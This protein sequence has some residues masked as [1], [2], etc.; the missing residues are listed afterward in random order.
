MVLLVFFFNPEAFSMVFI[1]LVWEVCFEC[2]NYN[3]NIGNQSRFYEGGY[4]RHI[5]TLY[6]RKWTQWGGCISSMVVVQL[7]YCFDLF[8]IALDEYAPFN[9]CSF[10]Q[11]CIIS[12][13]YCS[14]TKQAHI[15]IKLIQLIQLFLSY[16]ICE[17]TLLLL[18]HVI[19]Y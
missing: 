9:I 5:D 18:V 8:Q 2:I 19:Y 17:V 14:H 6:V 15:S 16:H 12:H 11:S 1:V 4:S 13:I 3:A 10:E 7:W